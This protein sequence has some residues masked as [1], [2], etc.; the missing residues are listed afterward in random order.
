MSLGEKAATQ[1]EACTVHICCRNS[2]G[3]LHTCTPAAG[4]HQEACTHAHLLHELSRSP[5]HLHSCPAAG[6]QQE[7]CTHAHL[8]Q[9]EASQ[10]ILLQ[11]QSLCVSPIPCVRN[12][13]GVSLCSLSVTDPHDL[14]WGQRKRSGAYTGLTVTLSP[15]RPDLKDSE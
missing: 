12:L 2:A 9:E 3:S 14:L 8:R 10:G 6:A 5:A 11:L 13:T 15:S 4:A 1:Q 7:A